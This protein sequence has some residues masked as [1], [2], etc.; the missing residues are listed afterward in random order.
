MWI[1]GPVRRYFAG[2]D[3]LKRLAPHHHHFLKDKPP[4]Q[5]GPSRE[6]CFSFARSEERATPG[7]PAVSVLYEV[8]INGK[9]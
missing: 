3:V 2:I 8:D 9:T 4:I 6:T 1:G 5:P 7:L